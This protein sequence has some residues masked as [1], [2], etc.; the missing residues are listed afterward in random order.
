[1]SN[2]SN[3]HNVNLFVAGKSEP[4]TGQRLAKIGYKKTAKQINPLPSICVSIP[5]IDTANDPF[6]EMRQNGAFDGIIRNAL[7]SAQ[8]GI[9]RS[10]YETSGGNLSSV[11]DSDIS[12]VNCLAYI[13]AENTGGRLTIDFLNAWFDANMKDNLTVII[14]DKLGFDEL[15]DASL[16]VIGQHLSG[17]RSLISSLSGG[18]TILTDMQIKQV[19]RALEIC[20]VDDETSV[21]LKNRLNEMQ[22]KPKISDLLEF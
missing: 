21:K 14:A 1:M 2:V 10:L 18:K 19:S 16:E 6:L 20:S 22:K 12:L 5:P 8:D 15:T 4:L 17:Y 9:I 3:R 7:E 13:E 11:S